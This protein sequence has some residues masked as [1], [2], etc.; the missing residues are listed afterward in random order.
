MS[1][2]VSRIF[3]EVLDAAAYFAATRRRLEGQ[4]GREVLKRLRAGE[5]GENPPEEQ[6]D[7]VF[8]ARIEELD[9]E[10]LQAIRKRLGIKRP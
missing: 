4:A 2:L 7:Q 3:F 1:E 6:L 5:F 10:R 9:A 8:R